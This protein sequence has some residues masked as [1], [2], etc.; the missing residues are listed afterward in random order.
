MSTYTGTNLKDLDT[1]TGGTGTPIE[2]NAPSE[3]NDAIREIKRVLKSH[4]A[5]RTETLATPYTLAAT[6]EVIY[7]NAATGTINLPQQ[8][9][10]SSSSV[11]K[12]YIIIKMHA[13]A[14]AITID[15]YTTET[16][17]GATTQTLTNQYDYMVIL[18]NGGTDWLIENRKFGSD[19]ITMASKSIWEAEGAAIASAA[20]T[21]IWTTDGNTAHI[22]GTVTI[23]SLGTA[24]QAGAWKKVIFDGVLLLTHGTNL[25]LQG[26]ANITTAANDFAFVYAD[27]TTSLRVV[28]NKAD[29][30]AVSGGG[31]ALSFSVHK[32]GTNQT[33]IISGV[34]TVLTW[35]TEE[36]DTQNNFASNTFTPTIAGKYHLIAQIKWGAAVDAIIL[37]VAIYKNGVPYKYR[38]IRSSGAAADQTSGVSCIADANGTTDYFNAYVYHNMGS[39]QV[40]NG[41]TAATF[42]QGHK[43]N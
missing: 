2:G 16:I 42:F 30:T 17:N 27:T 39:D 31:N 9:S 34:W 41:D 7:A 13:T 43:I 12:R 11:V 38:E 14:G 8:S 37:I 26:S 1:S 3:L 4:Y 21:D 6:D 15:G 19:V 35:S 20:T 5:T 32:N 25:N 33:G 22:T 40:A 29:G 24:P 28:Y 10:V 23:T 18:G 36:W